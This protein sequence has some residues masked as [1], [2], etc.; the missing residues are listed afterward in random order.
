MG[1]TVNGHCIQN[2]NNNIT[3]YENDYVTQKNEKKLLEN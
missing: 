3:I 2:N 1:L